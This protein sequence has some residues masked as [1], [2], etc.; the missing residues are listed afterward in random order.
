[1]IMADPI[2]PDYACAQ[3][4]QKLAQ[5]RE[6]SPIPAVHQQYTHILAYIAEAPLGSIQLKSESFLIILSLARRCRAARQF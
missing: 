6:T 2:Y 4:A 5:K 1:M 3:S